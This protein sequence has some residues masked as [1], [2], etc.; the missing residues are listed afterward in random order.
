MT[1]GGDRKRII[2]LLRSVVIATSAYVVVGHPGRFDGGV[3]SEQA[4]FIVGF[5]FSNLLLSA[6]PR[7]LFESA[8]F[9]PVLL[10][11]DTA[12]I[13][14]GLSWRYGLS[15]DLL[16]MYFLT[17]FLITVGESLV[18]VAIGSGVV[19]A[20]YGYWLYLNGSVAVQDDY[21]LRLPFFFLIAIF[22]GSLTEQLKQERRRRQS[23]ERETQHLR[24]LLDL[25]GLFS[26]TN[27]TREFVR[28][29][30]GFVE[31]ACPGLRCDVLFDDSQVA[32]PEGGVAFGMVAHGRRYGNL[33]VRT[34]D[35]RPLSER[36]GCLCQIVA[37]AAAG[38]LYGAEQCDAA[39]EA[40]ELKEQFLAAISHELRTPLHAILG[41]TDMIEVS[42]PDAD[43]DLTEGIARMRL[44]ASRLQDLIEQVLGLAEL[45][46]G[47]RGV[48]AE[49]LSLRKLAGELAANVQEQLVGRP[50]AF[51]WRVAG[52]VDGI[53]TDRRKLR[54]ALVCVLNNAAKFTEVGEI[55]LSI[56]RR[57]D[58]T[59]EFTIRD[60]GIGIRSA[61]LPLVFDD[62]RQ[63]DGSLTRRYGGLG[64]GLTFARE[65]VM[66]LGGT[67]EIDSQLGDGTVVRL[68]LPRTYQ[69]PHA[70]VSSAPVSVP[71]ASSQPARLSWAVS[72][73]MPGAMEREGA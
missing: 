48:R 32:R 43:P 36:E 15:Q 41:Y 7:A 1:N 40:S 33:A 64:M 59:I 23:A 6:A 63:I 34:A 45:R 62:F 14:F 67:V 53:A 56:D 69:D 12:F 54:Q 49:E 8:Y 13:L 66:L 39:K 5:V 57:S 58:G 35:G 28:G 22:Y 73:S 25:A 16:L 55:S 11:A 27:P 60:S 65:L 52:D 37:H 44:N 26:E 38:A 2:L 21:W 18:A 47:Q 19:S 9:G 10:L 70:L 4:L 24:L 3:G 20:L 50:I 51:S 31:A 30:G 61:D 72:Q 29:I 17:V 46:G 68:R 42:V 71:E